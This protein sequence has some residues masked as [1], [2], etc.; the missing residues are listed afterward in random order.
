MTE[1]LRRWRIIPVIIIEDAKNAVPLADALLAGGLPIAEITLR[2]N[3]ALEALRRIKDA[4]P[5]MF[6]GAGTVLNVA[7]AR[8]AKDAGAEF[9][10]SPGFN[11]S[12]VEYCLEN[13]IPV[14]P[15]VATASE[16]E[17]VLE[18]GINLMKLWP[19]ETLGGVPYLQLLGGPFVGVEFNP[20]GG[21]TATNFTTYLN[22]K[23]VV[24]VGGNW[25]APPDWI[26]AGQFERIREIVRQTV[27]RVAAVSQIS[28]TRAGTAAPRRA[29]ADQLEPPA[30]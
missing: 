4:Q 15:G 12:V 25:M 23:N 5:E 7:Q 20:S 2:T 27:T 30:I 24:A 18:V 8:K 29:A 11:R 13:G 28:G 22:Q 26:S 1:A 21:V 14:Y 10:V 19:I 6:A 9:V 3:G 16:I 17:A